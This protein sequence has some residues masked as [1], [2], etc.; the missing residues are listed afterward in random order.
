MTRRAMTSHFGLLVLFALFVSAVFAVLLR[1]E[2]REQA[3]LGAR[4]VGG[5][6]G[7]GLLLGWLLY[8]LP[9]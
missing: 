6:V 8:P 1:D 3:W 2:P 4:L 5:F 9:L 7:A